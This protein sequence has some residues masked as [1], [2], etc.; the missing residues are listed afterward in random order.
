MRRAGSGGWLSH[1]TNKEAADA[2]LPK[3]QLYNLEADPTE[4]YNLI[5]SNEKRVADMTSRLK[6]FVENGRTTSGASQ[7]NNTDLSQQYEWL[8]N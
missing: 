1:P 2:G 4:Q 8:S 7:N 3:Y 6:E 5:E